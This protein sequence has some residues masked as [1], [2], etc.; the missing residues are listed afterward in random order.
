MVPKVVCQQSL[1]TRPAHLPRLGRVC[2]GTGILPFG[3]AVQRLFN[4]APLGLIGA[5][6]ISVAV[7]DDI[8]KRLHTTF[9][10]REA[11]EQLK[12]L[13]ILGRGRRHGLSS[14]ST[15][16]CCSSI[17]RQRITFGHT[18]WLRRAWRGVCRRY[19]RAAPEHDNRPGSGSLRSLRRIRGTARHYVAVVHAFLIN[20]LPALLPSKPLPAAA[21]F[22]RTCRIHPTRLG[23]IMCS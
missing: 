11:V 9:Q 17:L 7:G 21:P 14:Y 6:Q 5:R 4:N 19:T 2:L 15:T 1:F 16:A 20:S 18:P 8:R 13:G 22:S 12:Q 23:W 3:P 10:A